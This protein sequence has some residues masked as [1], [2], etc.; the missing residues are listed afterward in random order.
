LEQGDTFFSSIWNM[1]NYFALD[2]GG[3]LRG[4]LLG[5]PAT[6]AWIWTEG[7]PSDIARCEALE[8]APR[9]VLLGR[10][11][12]QRR[13]P[14]QRDCAALRAHV[15]VD[16]LLTPA[17]I[18]ALL[19]PLAALSDD[20]KAAAAALVRDSTNVGREQFNQR[21]RIHEMH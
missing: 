18:K 8:G 19:G 10:A 12:Y 1:Y 9:V 17:D 14:V 7:V 4:S 20:D 21:P 15:H 16:A 6:D 13:T 2:N 5:L 11:P 3:Q